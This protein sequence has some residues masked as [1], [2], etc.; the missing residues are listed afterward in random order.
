[1]A[2]EN[3]SKI[4]KIIIKRHHTAQSKSLPVDL[5]KR[6]QPNNSQLNASSPSGIVEICL[7]E[8]E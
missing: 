4:L 5:P 7:N 1:M 8:R 2:Q 3:N 6:S